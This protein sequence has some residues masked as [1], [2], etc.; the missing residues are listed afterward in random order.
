MDIKF[1]VRYDDE[2]WTDGMIEHQ[3]GI[4]R[5]PSDLESDMIGISHRLFG[6]DIAIGVICETTFDE[7]ELKNSLI[8]EL[9][10]QYDEFKIQHQFTFRKAIDELGLKGRDVG[11]MQTI[12]GSNNLDIGISLMGWAMRQI[13][14]ADMPESP[15]QKEII[16]AQIMPFPLRFYLIDKNQ[17]NEKGM[18]KQ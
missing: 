11:L 12:D 16:E 13:V 6:L 5:F 1:N 9:E 4:Y 3:Q 7:D 18:T 10:K 14:F 15:M 17:F 8:A 2:S